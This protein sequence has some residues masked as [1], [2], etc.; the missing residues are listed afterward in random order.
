MNF[1]IYSEFS[2]KNMVISPTAKPGYEH[3]DQDIL[4]HDIFGAECDP[5]PCYNPVQSIVNITPK[6]EVL[7]CIYSIWGPCVPCS[8]VGLYTCVAPIKLILE[9][10]F[11]NAKKNSQFEKYETKAI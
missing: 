10:H 9:T 2:L 3:Q 5:Y 1:A 6:G 8:K 4:G 7:H 11:L